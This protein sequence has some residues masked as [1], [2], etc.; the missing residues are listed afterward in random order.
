MLLW[1]AVANAGELVREVD[2][3]LFY[4]E[5][6]R[7]DGLIPISVTCR[8]DDV[9]FDALEPLI[10]NYANHDQIWKSVETADW[11]GRN[12]DWLRVH[13]VHTIPGL[14]RREVVLEWKASTTERGTRHDWRRA[15]EQ[16]E[17]EPGHVLIDADEGFYRLEPSGDGVL[18]EAEFVYDPSGNIP[19]WVT[20]KTQ[21]PTSVLMMNELREAAVNATRGMDVE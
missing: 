17:P 8:W 4:R 10:A 1:L 5:D 14:A 7:A 19:P 21:I 11:D 16:R 3:C 13:H 9:R 18:L 6:A 12:G 2:G 15:D 20:V